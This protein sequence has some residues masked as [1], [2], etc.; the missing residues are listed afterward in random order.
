MG[1]KLIILIGIE[2]LYPKTDSVIDRTE[3]QTSTYLILGK[4]KKGGL[5]HAQ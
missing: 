1:N 4:A 3:G 2:I 5:L